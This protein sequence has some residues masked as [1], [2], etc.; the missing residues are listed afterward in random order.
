MGLIATGYITGT[1]AADG[2]SWNPYNY[3]L[4]VF[5]AYTFIIKTIL[6][7]KS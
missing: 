4:E 3:L 6:I 5:N 7:V 2:T 1:V